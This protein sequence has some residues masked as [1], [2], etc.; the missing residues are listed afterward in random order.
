MSVVKPPETETRQVGVIVERRALDNPWVDHSWRPVQILPAAPASEPWTK[1]AEGPGWQRFYAGPAELALFRHESESYQYN[2]ESQPPSVWVYLRRSPDERGIE[3]LGASCDPGEAHAHNDTGDDI[4][5]AVPM[6]EQILA[7]MSE[8]VRR[9]P[10]AKFEKRQRDRADTEA[11][12]RKIRL[13]ESD[14]KRQVPEDE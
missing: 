7:W 12:A 8:Y 3:L 6:P 14:P 2:L 11:L 9:H 1:I 10:P 4:V 13:H 5:D